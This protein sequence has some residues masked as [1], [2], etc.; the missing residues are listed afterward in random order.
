VTPNFHRI[1]HSS[2]QSET[3][4]NYGQVFAFWDRLFGSY[5]GYADGKRGDVE[6]GLTQLRDAQSQRLDQTLL[7]PIRLKVPD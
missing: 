1:H 3:D 6:Y 5:S 2:R 4:S 7:L